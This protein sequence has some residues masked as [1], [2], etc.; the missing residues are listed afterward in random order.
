LQIQKNEIRE[1]ILNSARNEFLEKGFEKSSI[2][3]MAKRADVSKS[4]I[5]NY[6]ENKNLLFESVV[7]NTIRKIQFGFMTLEKRYKEHGQREY[8]EI[9][10]KKMM[11]LFMDFV[12]KHTTD[13]K[14]LLFKSH[15]TALSTFKTDV[16]NN[17]ANLF[18]NW[19][20]EIRPDRKIPRFFILSVSG[21]YI[22]TIEKIIANDLTE[23]SVTEFSD[24]FLKFIH[25]GWKAIFLE[26]GKNQNEGEIST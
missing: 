21:F 24:F 13:L 2:R 1:K 9:D 5:Y 17:L 25:G 22:D 10:Q 15:G 18:E 12:F 3:N 8:T 23:D 6:F 16:T 14:L 7:R 20:S 26:Y 19:L 4:N 11:S